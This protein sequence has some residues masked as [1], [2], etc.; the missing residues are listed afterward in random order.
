MKINL[1]LYLLGF[2]LISTVNISCDKDLDNLEVQSDAE[3]AFPLFYGN[4]DLKKVIEKSGDSL[5][6]LIGPNGEM[7]FKYSGDI[8][9][10]TS[11][12]IY[13]QIPPIPAIITDTFFGVPVKLNNNISLRKATITD[14]T[15]FFTTFN[16]EQ[17]VCYSGIIGYSSI[18]ITMVAYEWWRIAIQPI[19]II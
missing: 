16:I 3:Y 18:C 14:G 2:I 13:S 10:R 4:L 15:I 12:E 11:K 7:S 8:V 6:L 5:A 9:S 1:L 17:S 19:G